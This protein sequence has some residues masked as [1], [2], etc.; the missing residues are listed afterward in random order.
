MNTLI[1]LRSRGLEFLV[2]PNHAGSLA[3][4]FDN[5]TDWIGIHTCLRNHLSPINAVKRRTAAL[6]PGADGMTSAATYA[7]L[8]L[9][10]Q[11]IFIYTRTP[12]NADKIIR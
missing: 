9:G 4:L 10:V 2:V 11:T 7:A 12:E 6:I 3:A 8:R 5:S 1:P